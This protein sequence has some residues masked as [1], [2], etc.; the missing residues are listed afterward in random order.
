MLT[1]DALA[2][3]AQTA[4]NTPGAAPAPQ[5][6]GASTPPQTDDP[7][8]AESTGTDEEY[9]EE[10]VVV[11]LQR[12]M[13]KAQT[14]KRDSDQ[15]VDSVVAQ[16]I[17]KLPDV[18]VSE[19]A[20]RI[21]GVQVAR[22]RGE[23]AG[24][25]LVRGLPDVTTTYNG[26]EIFTAETRS[27]ALADFPSGG[28]AALE[29]FKTTT[30]DQIEGGLAG[31]IDVRSRRPLDFEGFEL[32]G[33]LRGTYAN[34]SGAFDPNGNLLITNRWRT[35]A[36]DIGALLNVSYTRLNY[37]DSA[38]WNT[39]FISPN[40][41]D[42]ETGQQFRFPDV[43]GIFYGAGQRERPSVNGS[44]QWRPQPGLEFYADGLWQ[45][46]RD[47]VSDRQLEMRLWGGGARYTNVMLRPGT[48][49]Q[50]QSLTVENAAQPFMFQGATYRQTD[51]AQF[52]V[53]GSYETGPVRLTADLARTASQF[54][55][56]LYSFDQQL[57]AAPTF[58]VNFDVPRGPGGMEF[59]LRDYDL[60]NPAN[61]QYV[62]LFDRSY[63]AGGDDWQARTDLDV[64]TGLSFLP[65]LEAGLRFTTRD[66]YQENGQRYSNA[67]A[68]MPL[69]DIPVDLH[70]FRGGFRGSDI[71]RTRTWIV[72]PYDSIR[73]NVDQLRALE[74]FTPGAPERLRVFDANEQ[75]FAGY[76]QARYEFNVGS[77]R[78][79]GVLGLRAVRT[80]TTVNS[81][82]TETT[83][84]TASGSYTDLLPN[85]SARIRLLRDL[86]LRLSANQTRT[87]PGFDQLRPIV[88]N[89]PPACLSEPSPPP[90]CQIT[91]GGGN[92]DLEPVRSNNYDASL[93]Y[94][95]LQTGMASLA[96]FRRD[97]NGFITN[98]DV[99]RDDPTYGPGRV[100]VNIPVNAGEGRIQGFEATLGSFFDFLPGWLGG[101]GAYGN[102]TYLNDEQA[103]PAG[104]QL[105]LG[106]TG[107]I[108][109]VSNWS[110]NLVA[111]YE[112]EKLS[113]RLAYNYRSRWITS[114][115][116]NPDGDGFTGEYVDGVSRLDFS[117]SYAPW[118]KVSF[119]FDASN[120][121]GNPFRSFRQFT[122]EGDTYPR[123]VRYE[124]SVY[125]LGIRVRI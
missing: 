12:S 98:L 71:Q 111:M 119:T 106:E 59:S 113:A 66:A 11:G 20:A 17:G 88:L 42:A 24:Q 95:F 116:Q 2:Q 50:A 28:I 15:I 62:G 29:V 77:V 75:S 25:V 78:V 5:A 97:F 32:S 68:G 99:T 102:V 92:P 82:P 67:H 90:S 34:Q 103:F 13:Q 112:R 74:G 51:T 105:A 6:A 40:G 118:E 120:I 56:S 43:V 114:Y 7:A 48:T 79:D 89:S 44:V 63:I 37:L 45:G 31:L 18:T 81:Y 65:K 26:R 21:P 16:D 10:I 39:G 83:I 38:R 61:F 70:V 84:E 117:A 73:S 94:Y 1:A 121:L 85:V 55:L 49:D 123:D 93:E 109:G 115:V 4:P 122:P 60:T 108:P 8:T 35:G 125:S 52:A 23:A 110:Y 47:S 33:S 19:T 22:E 64:S 91:G 101:F 87:R 57:A 96:V 14:I 36:G 76:G 80:N 54:D 58:D 100:R 46:Y 30:A 3:A 27:V 124:E 53:G 72:P 9:V 41:R 107:R 69:T 104:Y 86:Q